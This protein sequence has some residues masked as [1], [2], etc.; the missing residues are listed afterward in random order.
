MINDID[1]KCGASKIPEYPVCGDCA[2][3]YHY[4]DRDC[5]CC[6][7]S[8]RIAGEYEAHEFQTA[9]EDFLT[10]LAGNGHAHVRELAHRYVQD[11]ILGKPRTLCAICEDTGW[12]TIEGYPSL[13]NPSGDES[14]PCQCQMLREVLTG[15]PFGW[16]SDESIPY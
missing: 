7:H 2:R 14:V 12:E 16:T 5:A 8:A 11:Q 9:V 1:C 6:F 10:Y 3:V 4:T 13:S 15:D